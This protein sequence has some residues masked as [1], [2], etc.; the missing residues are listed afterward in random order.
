MFWETANQV[1][2]SIQNIITVIAICVGAVWGYFRFVRF[3]TLK[4]RLEFSFDWSNTPHEK[5]GYVVILT[6]RLSNK[7]NSK[8]DLRKDNRDMC[9]LKYA[10]RKAMN[11]SNDL[12]IISAPCNKLKHLGRIFREHKWI[13]PGE[14]IDDVRVFNIKERDIMAVQ[15]EVRIY[16]TKKWSSS[17]AFPLTDSH[18]TDNSLSEDEQDEYEELEAAEELLRSRIAEAKLAIPIPTGRLSDQEKELADIMKESE[19]LL[20]DFKSV[21]KQ[22]DL[23]YKVKQL[24]EDLEKHL[25][26]G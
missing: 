21:V 18:I 17:V 6:L 15:F 4:P 22:P 1:T 16:G 5:V 2:S 12:S 8:V 25:D 20:D 10:T 3:R 24:I 7:G 14:T 11:T 13:E 19:S 23:I 26:M 9:L